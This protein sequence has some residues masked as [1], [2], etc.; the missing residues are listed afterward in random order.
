MVDWTDAQIKADATELKKS[1]ETALAA[2]PYSDEARAFQQE[3]NG[4]YDRNGIAYVR[5]VFNQAKQDV[6]NLGIISEAAGGTDVDQ[7]CFSHGA[8]RTGAR[9]VTG[10]EDPLGQV[11]GYSTPVP[12]PRGTYK[13]ELPPKIYESDGYHRRSRQP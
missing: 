10:Q 5:S 11:C 12:I 13:V 2:G 8:V 4:M 7:L 6:G 1:G 3:I 9:Y